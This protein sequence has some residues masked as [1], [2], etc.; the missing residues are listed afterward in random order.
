MKLLPGLNLFDDVF[1]D[2]F[3][4]PSMM[5]RT[6]NLMKTDVHLKDGNYNLNMELPGYK[7]EDIQLE[8]KDG[9]LNISAS[10]NESSDEKDD[11]G[12]IIR[13]ER[14]H[15]SCSRSFYVGD[16]VSQEDIKARFENGE[17]LI[18]F[19]AEIAEKTKPNQYIS[20]D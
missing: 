6:S 2:N 10:R 1:N 12:N 14:Y 4:E 20:I 9:Y 7:K 18:S 8:L 19:P 16:A 11:K 13:Q 17:L 15:G 3:W 5:K